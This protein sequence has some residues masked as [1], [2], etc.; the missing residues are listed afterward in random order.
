M[1]KR[2]SG[3]VLSAA[4]LA[5]AV[6]PT[7]G[8]GMVSAQAATAGD[9]SATLP[10]QVW[11]DE[12]AEMT[13]EGWEQHATPLGNG[14]LGAMVFGGVAK[15][16][17]QVNEHTI[18]SGGPGANPDY[19]GGQT[20]MTAQERYAILQDVRQKLQKVSDA[21]EQYLAEH[22][23]Y[24]GSKKYD[25]F[26]TQCGLN[27]AEVE[28]QIKSLF[29][30]K[31]NFG[32]Y[33][34]LEDIYISD[35]T[36]AGDTVDGKAT[37][38]NYKRTLDLNEGVV[39]VSYRQN[40]VTYTREYFVSNP[41]N[42]MVVRLTASEKG[43]LTREITIDS[44]HSNKSIYADIYNNTITMT[45][46]PS[47]QS[48]DGLKFAQQLKVVAEGGSVMTLGDTSYVDGADS[49]TV[50][51]TA[52]T[53]YQQCMDDSYD[54]FSD[55]DPLDAVEERIAAAVQNGYAKQLA[56]HKAD[57][58]ALFNAMQLNVAGLTTVPNKT[59][60]ELLAAYR[61]KYA[62]SKATD[63]DENKDWEW[64]TEEDLYLEN[65]YFQFGR[66][67]LIS[68][69]RE[70]SL[71][72]N[73]QG[74]WADS[75]NPPWNADYHTNINLQMNY[76]LAEQTNLAECH[77][78]VIEYINAQVPRGTEVA[79]NYYCTQDGDPVRGWTFHHENNIW[80]NA[81][82]GESGASYAPESA[83]WACLD[84]WEY[85][86]FNQDVDFL[87]DNFDTL[88]GAALFWVDNL[89][90]DSN[91]KLVAS[92]SYS[93]E[94]GPF[95]EGATYVQ[96]VVW[97]IFNE[98]IEASK[99]L[100]KSGDSEVK[101]IEAA[102]AKMLKPSVETSI[103]SNGQFLEWEYETTLDNKEDKEHR[104]TNHLFVLHP[105]NQIVAGRSEEEDLLVEAM[106]KT[107]NNRTD[108][109]TG[110]SKAWKINFWARTRVGDRSHKVLSSLIGGYDQGGGNPTTA[111][112]LFDLHAPFQIDGNFGA[113][114]GIAEMLL[115]S[116]GDA[117]ELLA[118]LPS[119]W[120]DGTATG[121]KARGNVEVDMNWHHGELVTAVLRPNTDNSAL[122]VKGTNIA[123]G[124]LVDSKG[125]DVTF[126]AEGSDTIVFNAKADETYTIQDIVDPTGLTVAKAALEDAITNAQALYNSKKPTDE[127]YDAAANKE[128]KDVIDAAQT[129]LDSNTSDKF[130]LIDAADA[131]EKAVDAFNIAYNFTLTV[132]PGDGIYNGLQQVEA[133]CASNIVE[134]R[135]TLDGAAPTAD[136]AL[137]TGPIVLPYGSTQLRIAT[138][139]GDKLV[140]DVIARDYLVNAETDLALGSAA[141]DDSGKTI[142]GYPAERIVNGDRNSRW[143]TSSNSSADLVATID[144]KTPKTFDSYL[145]DEFCE[146]NQATRVTSLKVEYL[147]GTT[148]KE[149][150]IQEGDQWNLDND[151]DSA[152][153]S[154]HAYKAAS[155]EP[156][157]AQMLRLT[158]RG[159]NVSI[160]EFSLYYNHQ[161][162]AA[163]DK[164]DLNTLIEECDA[165]SPADYEDVSALEAPL[166]A[167][168]EVL[169]NADATISDV[170][171]A[172]QNLLNAKNALVEKPS[173]LPGDVNLDGRVAAEDAL[174][175]LQKA[176]GKIDL[177]DQQAQAA[178]VDG[179]AGVTANDALMIL[180]CATGK[181]TL[182]DKPVDPTDPDEPTVPTAP[183]TP[184]PTATKAELKAS[185]DEE[186]DPGRYTT[187]SVRAYTQAMAACEVL[188]AD[189]HASGENIYR[190]LTAL[191]RAKAGLQENPQSNWVGTFGKICGT[192]TVLKQGDSLLY[193]DW[194]QLDQGSIDV[195][196][197]RSNLCLQLTID[198]QSTNPA[199]DPAKMWTGLT[200]KL[201]S[202]D[203]AGVAGDPDGAGNTEHNYGW[204]L[205]PSNFDGTSTLKVSIPLD[206]IN[207]NKR[208][209]MDWTDV[210]RLIVQ[211]QLN[212]SICTGDMYQYTMNI[213]SA[214]IV[215]M[216]PINE[217]KTALTTEVNRVKDTNTAGYD[218]A[219]VATFQAALQAAQDLLKG[220]D[221][222]VNLYDVNKAK[223]DLTAA[224]DAM[225]AS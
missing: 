160:W 182:S 41:G 97:E 27:K 168:K 112:N 31:S 199:V 65:L 39:T 114:S 144:L 192:H 18:W 83:A 129:A 121:M 99:I 37:Y 214:R 98:V 1:K 177:T 139:H 13:H 187:A 111:D 66:Y 56:A 193:A 198:L 215:D 45:G 28:A 78:P 194:K 19:N 47:D 50:Y 11:Y 209:V 200:I 24:D 79:Q 82:P 128:L 21:F 197:N 158:M 172:Y 102:Q 151:P 42:V 188:Y 122:K 183:T 176:T 67:L 51:M 35:P 3:V 163:S 161:K 84:I 17:I 150:P 68:S 43:K 186:I 190:A 159:D 180:Q 104:H 36:V 220:H 224:Y 46:Q 117:I 171:I 156:V 89:V 191:N 48:A 100:G 134:V 146:K 179:T 205:T 217:A 54:Y 15:D 173:V 175:A 12:P 23:D 165:L 63:K 29:G 118:A 10:L 196:D 4:M 216:V 96:G 55:E 140:G 133:T 221:A 88:K 130:V 137:Y 222:L 212:T 103:G 115:Q 120:A 219:K 207:T 58:K 109:G 195:S 74:I 44:P 116:Q 92:P 225:I 170:N 86:Q 90:E 77:L 181:I 80:G 53:N 124:K 81:A 110:W 106:K 223:T 57:Y 22:P 40:G 94:H 213:R 30:E 155:F 70:G 178:D 141:T 14:F 25:D 126:T 7:A 59:T 108:N 73:L 147:D 149:L 143:A 32:S 152:S 135:Y 107:L 76:W 2:V 62:A 75:L 119:A 34:T 174:M 6:L 202:A 9:L 95:T 162:A 101:E 5:S 136:S 203:K 87:A 164:A 167:A 153:A 157:T 125:N 93:P 131:L 142:S 148:W 105:S 8:A 154:Q 138:F 127:L 61:T 201:R 71:P 64:Y 211:C 132:S 169:A 166:A 210:Q 208:G 16:K 218:A 145:L 85:Y 26:Y 60:D 69:S 185:M 91:G 20:D 33:Q 38:S 113:T 123:N 184:L 49:I 206:Q 204:N 189:E 52:G 72:A